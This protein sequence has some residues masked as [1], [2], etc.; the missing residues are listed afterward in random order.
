MC[1]GRGATSAY[2]VI[3]APRLMVVCNYELFLL[4]VGACWLNGQPV[5][6]MFIYIKIKLS[7]YRT[8]CLFARG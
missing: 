2:S 4:L 1:N 3:C 6:Y 8:V 5:F 7:Y